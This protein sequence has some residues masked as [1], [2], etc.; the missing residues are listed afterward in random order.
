MN[1][2]T[3][4]TAPTLFVEANGIDTPIVVLESRASCPCFSL[5]YFNSNLDAWDPAVTNGLAADH[6]V[7]LFEKRRRRSI[8]RR[9]ART[10][11]GM[12][13]T[14]CR[15][16]HYSRTEDRRCCRLFTRWNDRATYGLGPF[17]TCSSPDFVGNR[18][19]R[20]ERHDFHRTVR[21]GTSRPSGFPVGRILLSQQNQSG[22]GTRTLGAS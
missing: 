13:P 17:G 19:A 12:N 6:E 2:G 10:V 4:E 15:L 5:V 20:G 22:G 21:G 1:H 18:T 7:I 9:N 3:H 11:A 8:K 16:L 14:L